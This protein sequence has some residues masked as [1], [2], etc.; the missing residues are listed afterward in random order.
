MLN[1]ISK[2]T[3]DSLSITSL[4]PRAIGG[5]L[6]L[7]LLSAC[8]TDEPPSG[9]V[10]ITTGA[11]TDAWTAEPAARQ[12]RIEMVYGTTRT[13]LASVDA[14][15]TNVSIGS[16]GPS[17]VIASFDATAIDADSNTVMRGTTVPLDVYGIAGTRIPLFMGRV[18]AWARAPGELHF[19]RRHPQLALLGN[20]FV[21]VSGGDGAQT[22]PASFDVYSVWRWS[23][24]QKQPALPKVPESWAAFDPKLLLIDQ[25]GAIWLDLSTSSTSAVQAPIG[26]DFAQIVGGETL[27]GS[28]DTQYIVGATRLTGEP[29]NQ[30]LRLQRTVAANGAVD[31]KLELMK[32]GTPRLGAA[33]TVVNGQLLVV[34]GSDTG[35]GAEANT[36]GTVFAP[37]D[38]PADATHG[39]ALLALD[40]TTALL[41]G[42]RD[43]ATDEIA[44]FRTMD[45]GCTKDCSAEPIADADF[46]FD[47]VRLFPVRDGQ[48][49]A[50]GEEPETGETRLFTFDT[51]IGHALNE[52]ALRTPRLGASAIRLPNGQV[53]VVGGDA[54]EG[55]A[56]AM[57]M[58]VFFPQ[59]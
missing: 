33:A 8:S 44:G 37:L 53:A 7:L 10:E 34:G 49:L 9:V 21:L 54:V 11:E 19:P 12:V 14:P 50:V 42:G 35:P 22:I 6:G 1:T 47:R 43:P 32:L 59:P 38:F 15:A 27:H 23:V 51:G 56:P 24:V 45:L 30:I 36:A 40:A 31:I 5:L 28:D 17:N 18:G 41:A 16:D 13:P 26:L 46:A 52:Y 55:G 57:T 39:A 25:E 48:L 29:T 58:E 20:A 3:H 4:I 2:A